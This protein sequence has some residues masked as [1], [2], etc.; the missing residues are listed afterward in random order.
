MAGMDKDIKEK[1]QKFMAALAAG[2]FGQSNDALRDVGQI[3]EDN[4]TAEYMLASQMKI[5]FDR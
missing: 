1:E 3:M 4:Y 5:F 2:P